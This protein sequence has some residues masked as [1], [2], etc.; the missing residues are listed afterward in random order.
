MILEEMMSFAT[1]LVVAV[2]VACAI[3]ALY[4]SGIRLWA[5]GVETGEA[6]NDTNLIPRLLGGVCFAA[7]V[8]IVLFALWLMIPLFH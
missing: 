6:D 8:A 7:C 5:K 1:V 2:G 3:S 4:A